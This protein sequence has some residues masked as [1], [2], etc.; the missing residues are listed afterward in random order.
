VVALCKTLSNA[1]VVGSN[2][3]QGMDVYVRLYSV[4]VILC[5]G[6]SLAAV[7]SA[8]QGVLVP[9]YRIKKLLKSESPKKGL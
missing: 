3:T 2:P 4:C 5:A 7:S 8:V 1:G 9:V 6:R